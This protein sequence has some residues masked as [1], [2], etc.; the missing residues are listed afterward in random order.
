M[1][2]RIVF[3]SLAERPEVRTCNVLVSLFRPT[4]AVREMIVDGANLALTFE[5]MHY[6][7]CLEAL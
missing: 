1:T 5:A 3:T 2:L 7:D 4:I 6:L